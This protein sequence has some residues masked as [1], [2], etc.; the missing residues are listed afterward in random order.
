[1]IEAL[2]GNPDRFKNLAT[3]ETIVTT[4]KSSEEVKPAPSQTFQQA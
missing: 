1:M 3:M 4:T 2:N